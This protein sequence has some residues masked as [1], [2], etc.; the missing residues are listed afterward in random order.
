MKTCIKYKPAER[1][2]VWKTGHKS[3]TFS[4]A[5]G[6]GC[7]ARLAHVCCLGCQPCQTGRF[8]LLSGQL[9]NPVEGNHTTELICKAKIVFYDV[10]ID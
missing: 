4:L 2:V 1:P 6:Q 7:L 3:A 5:P 9:E 10:L 8:W